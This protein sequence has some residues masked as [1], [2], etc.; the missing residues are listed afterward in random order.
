MAVHSNIPLRLV[1]SALKIVSERSKTNV[2]IMPLVSYEILTAGLK[3]LQSLAC[4]V[5]N[6]FTSPY[7]A[8]SLKT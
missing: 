6:V 2:R 8:I 4:K 7:G 5:E 3:K 1:S